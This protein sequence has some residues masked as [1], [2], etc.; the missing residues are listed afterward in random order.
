MI[1]SLHVVSMLVVV[2]TIACHR[3]R[4]DV[5]APPSMLRGIISVTGTR[6]EQRIQLR[7]Q[8]RSTRLWANPGDSAALT[9]LGGMEVE[10][11]GWLD[12][13]GMRVA[14][15]TAWSV[16]GSR[17]VD[18]IVRVNGDKV[19]LETAK[20]LVVLGNPPNELRMMPG[21][22]VWVSGSLEK[23]PNSYGVIVPAR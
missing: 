7:T 3:Q 20:G 23:G 18:G 8:D 14:S 22:R 6:F 11:R 19:T 5:Q 17:V 16:S 12:E 9:R 10:T 2:S 4:T 21:A 15:F 13:S 1:V